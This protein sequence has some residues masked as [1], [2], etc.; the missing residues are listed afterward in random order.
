MIIID[1]LHRFGL[2]TSSFVNKEV[3]DFNRKLNKIINPYD[4][5]SQLHLN[6][7][8]QHFTKHGMHMKG[9]GNYRISGLLALRIM[10]LLTAHHLGTPIT[11]PWKAE[12]TEK[13]E[14]KMKPVVEESNFISLEL[15]VTDE[16]GKPSTSVKQMV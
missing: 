10:E 5:T 3:N 11:L 4:H 1:E 15:I 16:Q 12:T 7:Q 8:R 14:E 6:M 13:E 9:S 2:E